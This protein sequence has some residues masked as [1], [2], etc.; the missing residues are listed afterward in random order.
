MRQLH[1]YRTAKY[2][3]YCLLMM[4]FLSFDSTLVEHKPEN[5]KS[6]LLGGRKH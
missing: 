2:L 3:L 1:V 4:I 5:S 6:N